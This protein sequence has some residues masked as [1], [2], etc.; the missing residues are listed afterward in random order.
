MTG[1]GSRADAI[2]EALSVAVGAGVDD[3]AFQIRKGLHD[4]VPFGVGRRECTLDDVFCLLRAACEQDGESK[5]LVAVLRICLLEGRLARRG[6]RHHVS[7]SP[8]GPWALHLPQAALSV[9]GLR[10]DGCC[11]VA[12]SEG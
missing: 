2:P 1:S 5:H 3:G 10:P 6:C 11:S 12:T 4:R 7:Q 8:S 9:R